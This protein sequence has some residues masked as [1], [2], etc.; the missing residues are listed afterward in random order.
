MELLGRIALAALAGAAIGLE[1]ELRDHPAGVRTHALVAT[2]AALFTV[3]GQLDWGVPSGAVDPTRLPAQV[4][5][6]IGFIGAGAILR[7]G[8]GVR[9][10]TT[11]ATI[12]M[13]G[14]L[15]VGMATGATG[16]TFGA[17][18]LVLAVLVLLR[19]ARIVVA[20]VGIGTATL[21]VE[22]EIGHGTLRPILEAVE[23]LGGRI[24]DLAIDDDTRSGSPGTRRLH[25]AVS[26][27][28]DRFGRLEYLADAIQDRPEVRAVYVQR[29]AE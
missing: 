19:A 13:S 18:A 8:L 10:L 28:R 2:G 12:W 22:Y 17:L 4:V 5:S 3:A 20:R 6:G 7:D 29:P 14:A 9:G 1:R 24:E 15:G 23:E 11:A 21:D 27:R 16:L 26:T 25:L